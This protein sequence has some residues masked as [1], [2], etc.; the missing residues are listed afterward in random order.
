[1]KIPPQKEHFLNFYGKKDKEE[2]L[3]SYY[4]LR[5]PQLLLFI[6]EIA[7]VSKERLEDAYGMVKAYEDGN[8]LRNKQKNG[9]YMW[10][11]QEFRDFK[12]KLQITALVKIIRQ[13]KRWDDV[14][15]QVAKL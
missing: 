2:K 8:N 7:G 13:A 4:Y 15:E 10:G 12:T 9:N 5:C 1:M 6:A 14:K 11:R 3:P